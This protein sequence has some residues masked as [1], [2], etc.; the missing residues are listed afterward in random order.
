MDDDPAAILARYQEFVE[1]YRAYD[2]LIGA[3]SAPGAGNMDEQL[4]DAM[5]ACVTAFAPLADR[6]DRLIDLAVAA[7]GQGG[8][9]PAKDP[10]AV[11][12]GRKGGLKGGK[13]RAAALPPERRREIA[14]D[15]VRARWAKARG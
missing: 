6:G 13:A 1:C 11:A 9:D 5:D 14:R 10:D 8:A 2:R 4:W 3:Q 15:A 12:L 7:L